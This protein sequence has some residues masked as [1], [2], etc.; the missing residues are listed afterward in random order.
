MQYRF[1]KLKKS[2]DVGS[3][4]TKA[5]LDEQEEKR[6]L[7]G[8]LYRVVDCFKGHLK[9]VITPRDMVA[10]ARRQHL[11]KFKFNPRYSQIQDPLYYTS[12]NALRQDRRANW[13]HTDPTLC[14]FCSKLFKQARKD[15][16]PIYVHT[17]YRTPSLQKSL[18]KA[19]KS[20]LSSG[21][22]QRGA[23]LDI[24]HAHY[25]WEA[26]QVFWEYIGAVGQALIR[27]NNYPMQWGGDWDGDGI[28][29]ISDP[30][31]NYWDPAH[32][33]MRNWRQYEP[34]DP[35]VFDLYD[36]ETGELV[37]WARSPFAKHY[38]LPNLEQF[39]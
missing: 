5:Y 35:S 36:D 13:V 30:T 39:S 3:R 9:N 2:K 18:Q 11:E 34:I 33:Q 16:V 1:K 8:E 22:H 32:W 10:A 15:N 26:P 7:R 23:A 4:W 25:N 27:A 6:K 31:E 14:E 17:A 29:V 19:G 38:R 12:T 21:P 24:V 28:P 37:D 20:N